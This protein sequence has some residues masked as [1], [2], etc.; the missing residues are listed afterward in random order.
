MDKLEKQIPAALLIEWNEYLDWE[1]GQITQAVLSVLPAARNLGSGGGGG[2]KLTD[3][4]DI[5]GFL[6]SIGATDG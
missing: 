4:Q 1:L 2:I 5:S 6:T 3:P